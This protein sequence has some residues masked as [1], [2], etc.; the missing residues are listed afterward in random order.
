MA[1]EPFL[2]PAGVALRVLESWKK[3]AQVDP[4]V[5]LNAGDDEIEEEH[6]AELVLAD[7]NLD[8]G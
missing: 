2:E 8:G 4:V 3:N 7:L 1:H 6:R 5:D